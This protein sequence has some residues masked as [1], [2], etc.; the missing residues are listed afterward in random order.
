VRHEL[1]ILKSVVQ[2]ISVLV[3]DMLFTIEVPVEVLL[4]D[5][6]MLES[7]AASAGTGFDQPIDE[8]WAGVM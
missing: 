6:T 5:D 3:M 2:G 1:E 8:G 7:P 4:H